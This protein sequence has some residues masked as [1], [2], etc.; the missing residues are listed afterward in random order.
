MKFKLFFIPLLFV[1]TLTSSFA[2][3]PD[4][5]PKA[6]EKKYWNWFNMD[7][8]KDKIYGVSTEKAYDKVLKDKKST[9]VI[10]AIIDSGVDIEH[11]DIKDKIWVNE[12]EIAGNGIDDDQNGYIDDI[13]GW[14]FLGNSKGE[15]IKEE[16]LEVT[17][18]YKKYDSLFKDVSKEEVKP[19]D[20]TAY[21]QYLKVKQEYEKETVQ[22]EEELEA[23]IT[24][25][26]N[27]KIIDDIVKGYLQKETYTLDDVKAIKADNKEMEQIKGYI[28]SLHE[29]GF[30]SETLKKYREHYENKL[31]Y[32]LNTDFNP[33]TLIG[34][35][36]ENVLDSLYGNNDVEG[37]AS[38]HGTHV[39]GIVGAIRG[40]NVG[41]K[42]VA[43]NVQ[44]MVIRAVPDGDE[45]DKDVA[46]AIKYAVNNGAKIIN[47]SF[48]KSYSPQ[49]AAVEEAMRKAEEK[50]VLM[51][52]AAGNDAENIDTAQNFP[53]KKYVSS[54]KEAKNWLTIGASS[55]KANEEFVGSFSNYGKKSVDI[56]APGVNVYSLKPDNE[57]GTND[58]TSMASPVV[59]GV[60]ALIMSYY[61]TLSAEQVKEIILK[62][63]LKPKKLKVYLPSESQGEEEKQKVRLNDISVSGGL[64]NAYEAVKLAE[65]YSKRKNKM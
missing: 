55:N 47:M 58:G 25:E 40:N 46:N 44:L 37:E 60:A 26:K 4:P 56:F 61:P 19:E 30:D 2:F 62:S 9:P 39:A 49:K 3:A 42:G 27:F 22:A 6:E 18:L 13:H 45:R 57:Y 12:K 51:V 59:S 11:E 7:P 31:Q 16:T 36:P 34:D 21:N 1:L 33:R 63:S 48:G 14:N 20:K 8:K 50:G 64:V 65:R 35:D 23:I 52:H 53:N 29:K 5:D 24:F 32:H 38:D 28:I 54:G 10:V 41:V 43:E 17:R 15:N